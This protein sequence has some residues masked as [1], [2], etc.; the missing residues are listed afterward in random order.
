MQR[1][2]QPWTDNEI[3]T[4]TWT[5]AVEPVNVIAKRLGRS[6]IA[7]IRKAAGLKLG[8]L[9]RGT[10]SMNQLVKETGYS[11]STL[12]QVIKNIGSKVSRFR[13]G[14][15]KYKT[16]VRH[17]TIDQEQEERI[18]AYL[19]ENRHRPRIPRLDS[20]KTPPDMWGTGIKPPACTGCGT[21]KRPHFAKG[22]CKVCYNK[23][24]APAWGPRSRCKRCGTRSR[25][26]YANKFCRRCYD[27]MRQ[28][29]PEGVCEKSKDS[30]RWGTCPI[31]RKRRRRITPLIPRPACKVPRRLFDRGSS[32]AL[33]PRPCKP[34]L[35]TQ[36]RALVA[37][38]PRTEDTIPV[39]EELLALCGPV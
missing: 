1:H 7:I 28:I 31:T 32:P 18:I 2:N 37:R 9:R 16:D 36:L 10:K 13:R 26:P 35:R 6:E 12:H 8:G 19:R 3:Q 38:L 20:L 4:L 27:G 39:I 34:G 11:E 29:D 24:V 30:C 25:P 22:Q 21:T 15:R 17:I 5:W 33:E 23:K 14:D